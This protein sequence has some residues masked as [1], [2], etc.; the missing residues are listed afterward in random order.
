M[1]KEFSIQPRDYAVAVYERIYSKYQKELNY[2]RFDRFSQQADSLEY[3]QSALGPDVNGFTH[4]M[5]V[6]QRT[7]AF[8]EA[9]ENERFSQLEQQDLMSTALIHDIGE[10]KYRGYGPGD[11]ADPAKT[12]TS[13]NLETPIAKLLIFE[14]LNDL[15]GKDYQLQ[16]DQMLIKLKGRANPIEVFNACTKFLENNLDFVDRGHGVVLLDLYHQIVNN[17]T[18]KLGKSFRLIEK[19]QYVATGINAF[20]GYQP[21]PERPIYLNHRYHIKNSLAFA[22]EA[23]MQQDLPHVIKA[24]KEFIYPNK[25]LADNKNVINAIFEQSKNF[26]LPQDYKSFFDRKELDQSFELW[27]QWQ[28]A[29]TP[30]LV[31]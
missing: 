17:K 30:I 29:E 25:F 12:A 14:A 1:N 22:V 7:N 3:W 21:Y 26:F 20:K 19:I 13:N 23:S 31:P 18:T 11:V 5:V 16:L 6:A 15:S 2:P 10:M 27:Q 28:A 9:E 24:T 8:L 4:P